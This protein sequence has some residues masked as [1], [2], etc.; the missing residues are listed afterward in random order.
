MNTYAALGTSVDV[1]IDDPALAR[2]LAGLLAA[3]RVDVRLGAERHATA[4]PR[5]RLVGS[6]LSRDGEFLARFENSDTALTYLV[7]AVNRVLLET[8]PLVAVHAGAVRW[9]GHGLLLPGAQ[10]AG[11]TTLTAA[12]VQNGARYLTDE[13]AA[14]DR[15]RMLPYPKPLSLSVESLAALGLAPGPQDA[16]IDRHVLATDLGG[17]LATEPCRISALVF[18]SYSTESA[19]AA[20]PVGRGQAML[21]LAEETFHF[22]RRRRVS[23]EVLE[24]A[25]RGARCFR[26]ITG[27]IG[28]TLAALADA[29]AAPEARDP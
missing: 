13:A 17:E 26:L 22:D 3:L 15:D 7:H 10:G 2:G 16:A 25:T 4:K 20:V 28:A 18:P 14:F 21:W 9:N 29:L 6:D 23:L 12:L 11:K 24:R 5:L 8:T 27:P 1:D 19:P